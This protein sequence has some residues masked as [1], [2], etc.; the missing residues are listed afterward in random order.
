MK[1]HQKSFSVEIKKSRLPDPRP[2]LPPRRLFA[3]PPDE[4][5]A[6]VKETEPPPVVESVAAPRILPSVVEPVWSGS[7]PVELVPHNHSPGETNRGQIEFDLGVAGSEELE[8]TLARALTPADAETPTDVTPVVAEAAAPV[9]DLEPAQDQ[10]VKAKSRKPR[11]K[12]SRAVEPAIE[13]LSRPEIVETP[14]TAMITPP[15]APPK[16]VQRR[17]TKR[18]AAA[19]QLPRHERWKRRLHPASW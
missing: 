15:A 9:H 13:F 8:D 10:S 3:V 7:K 16:V 1:R 19:G 18:L 4:T 17:P 6:L 11:T 5:S 12:V 2:H 14:E